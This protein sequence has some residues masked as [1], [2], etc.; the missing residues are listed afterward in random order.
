MISLRWRDLYSTPTNITNEFESIVAQLKALWLREHN[1]DGSHRTETRDLAFTPVGAI[2]A[3]GGATAPTGWALCDGSQLNRL[4]YQSLFNIVGT[5]YGAGDGSTTFNVPDLRQKFP[6][7]KAASGT[8]A[9]L[10]STGGAIDHDHTIAG[11][12]HDA[13]TLAG[14]SHTHAAGTLAGPSHTHTGPSHSHSISASGTHTHAKGTLATSATSANDNADQ[15]F[16]GFASSFSTNI[17]THT[18]T[19]STAADGNHDHT[20]STGSAGT[21]NTGAGGTGS[22]TGSTAGATVTITGSTGSASGTSGTNN[23]PFLAINYIIYTGVAA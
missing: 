5:T 9:S 1:E 14:S 19:G 21:G 12:T 8:G 11:H 17:H 15:N 6:L 10:G 2:T 7:G 22:V 4:T 18:I 3:F 23:P 20:G 13:G 16:D